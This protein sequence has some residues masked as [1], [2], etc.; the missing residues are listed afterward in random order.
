MTFFGVRRWRRYVNKALVIIVEDDPNVASFLETT[1]AVEYETKLVTDGAEALQLLDRVAP[2][3][4]VLD[5]R[6]PGVSGV[7]ICRR[8]RTEQ[9]LSGAKLLIVTGYPDSPETKEIHQI[10]VDALLNKP[11][12]PHQLRHT[13]RQLLG[14]RN[15]RGR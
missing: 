7:D 1:L 11:V 14:G 13:V 8:I 6:L 12:M 15:G 4:V 3:L 5:L 2:D 9:R 10:G